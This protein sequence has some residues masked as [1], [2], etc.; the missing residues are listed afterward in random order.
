MTCHCSG[1]EAAYSLSHVTCHYAGLE[2]AYPSSDISCYYAGSEAAYPLSDMTRITQDRKQRI[3]VANDK[4]TTATDLVKQATGRLY[5]AVQNWH[6]LATPQ[7]YVCLLVRFVVYRGSCRR[8]FR[9]SYRGTSE[10]DEG[11]LRP[12]ETSDET[13]TQKM[14][15][16]TGSDETMQNVLAYS[17]F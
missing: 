17:F 14:F 6:H 1:L 8:S 16:S 9:R 15:R 4:W 3:A 11:H 10:E 12:N 7:Q 13:Y 5:A 2:A